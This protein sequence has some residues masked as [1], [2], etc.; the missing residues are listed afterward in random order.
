MFFFVK[1][2]AQDKTRGQRKIIFHI[3]RIAITTCSG[4]LNFFTSFVFY[5]L[6][7][8]TS[9]SHWL[10]VFLLVSQCISL[11]SS[12]P[13]CLHFFVSALLC[14]LGPSVSLSLTTYIVSLCLP[15]SPLVFLRL[16][17]FPFKLKS[18]LAQT[19]RLV[20]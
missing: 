2:K 14:P 9:L 1:N 7:S 5:F 19:G 11:S 4:M 15:V 12:A 17:A 13:L 3:C 16:L 10:H 18:T 6:T 8:S 20:C